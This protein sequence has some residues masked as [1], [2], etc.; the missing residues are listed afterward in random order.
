MGTFKNTSGDAVEI[1]LLEL[2]VPSDGTF[3]V[4]DEFDGQFDANPGFTSSRVKSPDLVP[5]PNVVAGVT[6]PIPTVPA[7]V[8]GQIPA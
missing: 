7:A 5:D 2:R 6:G 3:E 1:P 8:P 4:P